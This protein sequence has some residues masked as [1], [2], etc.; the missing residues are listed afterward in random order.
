MFTK[1]GHTHT[2]DP[3][4]HVLETVLLGAR[5]STQQHHHRLRLGR[6]EAQ[7]KDVLVAAVVALKHRLPQRALPVQRHLLALGSHQVVDNVA[8]RELIQVEMP[9]IHCAH[10]H[11][12]IF[13]MRAQTNM[14][15]YS[16]THV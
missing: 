8:A 11:V 2:P 16:T 10:V 7:H 15:M 12:C 5:V 1:S 4:V 6:D 3:P 9:Y 14:Y 13:F